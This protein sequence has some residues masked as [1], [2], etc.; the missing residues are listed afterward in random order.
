MQIDKREVLR[1]LSCDDTI[2][3][4]VLE[5]IDEC[6]L[7]IEKLNSAK[8]TYKIF[9]VEADSENVKVLNSVIELCGMD[10]G[11]HLEYSSKC[12]IMA[13]TLGCQIDSRLRYLKKTDMAKAIVFDACASAAVEDICDMVENEIRKFAME[14]YSLGITTRYSPGYGDFP[15]T[16]Q[17]QIINAL[18]TYK[19]IGL[20]VTDSLILIPN[21]SVTAIVGL[22][23]NISSHNNKP[24]E[25]C[26]ITKSCKY[27]KGDGY[28]GL[29]TIVR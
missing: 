27:K 13:V 19:A 14:K 15:L 4:K 26:N 3:G 9:D 12:A 29:K 2:D 18:D 16:I 28:C 22:T 20:S 23:N 10:I 21:K 7:E 17:L 1:Y 6:I 24:C 8:Y 5:I 11:A 25:N